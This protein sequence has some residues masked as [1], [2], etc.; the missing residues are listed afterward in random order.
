MIRKVIIFF[1]N[2]YLLLALVLYGLFIIFYKWTGSFMGDEATYSQIAKESL[3]RNDYWTLHWKGDLW[4]EKPPVVIWL[5]ALA[6]RFWGISETSAHI[7]PGLFSILSA[8]VLYFLGQE[9]FKNKIAGFFSGFVFLTCPL[10]FLYSRVNMMDIPVGMFLSLSMLALWKILAGKEKWFLVFGISTGMAVMIKSVIGLLSFSI[11]FLLVIIFKKRKVFLSRFFLWGVAGF[12]AI[13]APWHIFMTI[14]FGGVFW[15]DY[16][17]FHIWA[18]FFQP[19]LPVPWENND[20]LSYFKLFFERSGIWAWIFAVSIIAI[21]AAYFLQKA[22]EREW[23]SWIKNHRRQWIFLFGWLMIVFLPF[24]LAQTK[25]P[26]YMVLAYFPL[27][28][29]VG[30]FLGYIFQTGRLGSLLFLCL[31]SLFNFLPSWR[32]RVSDFGEAHLLFPKILIRYFNFSDKGLIAVMLTGFLGV[33]IIFYIFRK[34]PKYSLQFSL[35]IIMGM[36]LLI[37]FNP[38]R[39]EFIKKLGG[40][41]SA[42]AQNQS[43]QLYSVMKPNQYSFHCVGAFYL[44]INSK[45]E[46]LGERQMDIEPKNKLDNKRLCFIEKSFINDEAVRNAILLYEEGAVV[47]CAIK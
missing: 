47:N 25:L 12:L 1:R 24:F 3:W 7:F 38:Y 40:D 42:L 30:G 6:F 19:I 26:N 5:T 46:K 2:N 31:L 37:P 4:F 34:K 45:I 21:W 41:I 10:I 17:G 44:P 23:K 33:A 11:L 8:T 35:I 43:V 15:R 18:R 39:N 22:K 27:A 16:F 32:L 20:Q 14:K 9:L 13:S 36:N 28:I 29:I